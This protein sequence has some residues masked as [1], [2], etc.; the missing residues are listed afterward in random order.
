M[1]KNIVISLF[2]IVSGAA[3]AAGRLSDAKLR[4][5]ITTAVRSDLNY[6]GPLAIV[7]RPN[8][9]FLLRGST[10]KG[11]SERL[12]TGSGK[13]DTTSGRIWELNPLAQ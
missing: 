7:I 5:K 13:I 1:L 12:M 3:F 11:G 6:K 10:I 9:D 2:V 8:G 4:T